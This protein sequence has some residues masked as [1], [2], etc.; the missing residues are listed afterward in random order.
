MGLYN[1]AIEKRFGLMPRDALAN[2][3]LVE[4]SLRI[5]ARH[6]RDAK[7]ERAIARSLLDLRL[8]RTIRDGGP[9]AV[10]GA[11]WRHAMLA[12]RKELKSLIAWAR[13]D[14][15]MR[16]L[17]DL[18]TIARRVDSLPMAPVRT[19]AEY[20]TYRFDLPPALTAL[21]FARWAEEAA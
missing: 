16:R 14:A 15:T 18:D 6:F 3:A 4:A 20:M 10:Q 13:G 1:R 17:F 19:M 11:G 7:G 8:P 2:R 12:E 5:P 9:P 21:A